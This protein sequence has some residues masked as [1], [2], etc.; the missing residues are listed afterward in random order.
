M[1][2]IDLPTVMSAEFTVA[3][4][5]VYSSTL[6]LSAVMKISPARAVTGMAKGAA[7]AVRDANR[8]TIIELLF[9]SLPVSIE[10]GE[11]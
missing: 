5:V 8:T 1:A 11:N 3:P 9:I 7:I 10:F 2:T 6:P 4:A